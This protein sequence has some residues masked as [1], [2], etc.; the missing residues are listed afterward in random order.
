MQLKN[1]L[2]QKTSIKCRDGSMVHL[3]PRQVVDVATDEIDDDHLRSMVAHGYVLV[4]GASGAIVKP[5][6]DN[7]L[8]K[9]EKSEEKAAAGKQ[10]E[11]TKSKLKEK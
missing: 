11:S 3:R 9:P 2:F 5:V 6:A 4:G 10:P 8:P 1:Q 7:E